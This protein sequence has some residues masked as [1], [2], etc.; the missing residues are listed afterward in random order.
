MRIVQLRAE[1]LKKLRA[2][3]IAPD[4]NVVQITGANGAGKTSVLDSIFYALAGAAGIATEPIRRGARTAKI[5]LDLGE[6]VVRREFSDAGTSLYVES[7]D[8]SRFPSPQRLLD[9]LLGELTFDPLAFTRMDGKQQLETLRRL[10]KLDVDVDAL[11]RLNV[12]DYDA[13]RDVNR[14]GTSLRE[15]VSS[16]RQQLDPS[17]DIAAVDVSALTARMEEASGHN[18]GIERERDRRAARDR[19]VEELKRRA[20]DQFERAK[21]LRR[22]ADEIAEQADMLTKESLRLV[23]EAETDLPLPEAIDV[24][25]IREDVNA[26]VRANQRSEQQRRQ[27]A[28][29]REAVAALEAVHKESEALTAAMEERTATKADAIARAAMPVPGLAFGDGQ[30]TLNGLPFEQASSAEQLRVSFAMA[31]AS[32]PKIRVVLIRDGSLLDD[33]SLA[34]VAQMADAHD[35]QV[36][37]ERVDTSG[38]VGVL[39]EDGAVAAVDGVAA[40]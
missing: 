27:R 10:V 1:N 25:A 20:T 33:A 5:R 13:R 37:I 32:N 34:L 12:R 7:Q 21:N 24:A 2:V 18:A 15:R 8:G 9:G 3:S 40:D 29:L 11:D 39:I 17:I 31:V 22:Q 28:E 23:A 4:G 30:V 38:H 6:L 35:M 16:L 14:R 26:A 19:Q 36:W